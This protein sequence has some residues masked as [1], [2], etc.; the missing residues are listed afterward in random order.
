M[1]DSLEART[2]VTGVSPQEPVLRIAISALGRFHM[3][4]LARQ[5]LRLGQEVD[6]FTGNPR[7]RVDRDLRSHTRTHPFLHVLAALRYRIPPAPKTTW[8]LDRNLQHFGCWL[9]R[10]V[11]T[12]TTD[13]LDGLDGP[14]PA[15]GRLM[16]SHGKAWVCNRGSAHI[17]TQK[18]L[19]EEEH[20][21]WGAPIPYFSLD[22]LERCLAEYAEADAIVVPSNF[23]KRSF[24]EQGVRSER[25]YVCPYGVELSMFHPMPKADSKFRVLFV[26]NASIRKGI[27]YLFEA[28]RPLIEKQLCELWL[29]G[30]VDNSAKAL[31]AKNQDLFVYKGIQPRA[32][33]A[34]MYS[35]GSVL[36]LPSIEEGLALVQAQA[37][38][39]GP[40]VIATTNTG[41]ENLFS[42]SVEGFIVPIRNPVAIR[43]KV[44]WMIGHPIE[45]T[46]MGAAALQRVK[47]FGGWNRYGEQYLAMYREILARKRRAA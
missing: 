32:A 17:L 41:A 28:L 34:S 45:R 47:S 39:C 5:M 40:P 35:Q 26:G 11:D 8:W 2:D 30:G 6:I 12:E 20:Q 16:K 46:D 13:I 15:A 36:V 10:S 44:E 4:D 19:L 23:A 31:L 37:M 7:C 25:V 43:D 27:G 33:L 9:A 29:I 22:G 14:G 38:A 1:T 3:F 42:D 21:R 18:A 24:V